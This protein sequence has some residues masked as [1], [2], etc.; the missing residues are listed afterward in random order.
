[1][2][3][4]DV[5]LIIDVSAVRFGLGFSHDAF[6]LCTSHVHAFFMHTFFLFFPIISMCCVLLCSFSF[7]QIDCTM[8]P[9][10]RKST[11]AQNL[12]HGSGS[13]SSDF[14][15]PSHI[16]FHDEKAKPTSLRTS[17][18]VVFI[19]NAKSFCRISLTLHYP[20]SFEL[21]DRNLY[22]RNPCVFLSCLYK[23]STPTYM[24]LILLCLS[25]LCD[26]E[27]HV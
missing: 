19:R 1:M 14:C 22:V 17:R 8:A 12:L 18:T 13:S 9:K 23:S 20:M 5:C 11:P 6:N 3:L 27:V 16:Q 4:L 10:Q 7:S 24:A 26:F 15:V 2:H 25:S 21:R